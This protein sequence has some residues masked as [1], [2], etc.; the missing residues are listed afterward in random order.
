MF[1]FNINDLELME[2]WVE[3]DPTMRGRFTFPLTAAQGAASS[4][5]IYFEIDP[6]DML[7]RHTH[8]AEE[9]LLILQGHVELEVDGE[10]TKGEPGSVV[11]VPA[12]A[13]HA[14]E[15][16]GSETLKVVGFFAA[17]GI[18]HTYEA[19]IEPFGVDI[20]VTPEP[21]EAMAATGLRATSAA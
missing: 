1:A 3:R 18:V 4:S 11:L 7:L 19:P 9:I 17:A 14:A 2:G 8:S 16:T 5:V 13:P 20:L 21:G 12:N 10:S 15:N 6:G